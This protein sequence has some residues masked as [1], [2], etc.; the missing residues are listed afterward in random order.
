MAMVLG[1]IAAFGTLMPPIF[2]GEFAT[3]VL[4]TRSGLVILGGVA[5]CLLG[6]AFAGAAGASKECEMSTEPPAAASS[7]RPTIPIAPGVPLRREHSG[8]RLSSR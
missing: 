3:L 6:I 5:A 2:R 8:A 7:S 4:G 1:Y